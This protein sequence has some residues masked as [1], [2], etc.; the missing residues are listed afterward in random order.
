[1][2]RG[3]WQA[4]GCGVTESDTTKITTI[5]F[6]EARDCVYPSSQH[7]AWHKVTQ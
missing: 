7:S 4:T 5:Q 6:Q 2:D 3:P 1:M